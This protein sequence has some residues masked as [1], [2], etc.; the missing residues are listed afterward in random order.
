MLTRLLKGADPFVEE[1]IKTEDG[2]IEMPYRDVIQAPGNYGQSSDYISN[3]SNLVDNPS[4][5][6]GEGR[7]RKIRY[8]YGAARAALLYGLDLE[9]SV[10]NVFVR[11][12]YS[13]NGKYKQYPTISKDQIGFSR[14]KTTIIGEDGEEETGISID[15]VNRLAIRSERYTHLFGDRG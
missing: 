3:R 13:I 6:T 7:P 1:W 5:W 2:H 14:L 10:G 4:Q 12:H 11:A 9:G 8:H 15:P